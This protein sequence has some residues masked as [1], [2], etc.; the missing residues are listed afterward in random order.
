MELEVVVIDI[1]K[2]IEVIMFVVEFVLCDEEIDYD[3]YWVNVEVKMMEI[4]E[5]CSF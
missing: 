5:S 2:V 4:I 3:I 1:E